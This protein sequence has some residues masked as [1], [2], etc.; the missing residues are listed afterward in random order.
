[1][2][3]KCP[4]KPVPLEEI[5]EIPDEI[6]GKIA[7]LGYRYLTPPQAEAIRKGLL[8][9]RNLIVSAPT[10]SGKTLIA[11]LALVKAYIDGGIGVYTCPLKALASEKYWEF[12][13]WENLL[14]LRVGISTGDYDSSG[15]DLEFYDLIVTTYERFDSILRHRPKWISRLKSLVIDEIHEIGDP[16]R[17]PVIEMIVARALKLGIQIIGLS[18]TIGNPW[19]LSSWISGDLV[20]CSWRPVPL[21]QG[22]YDKASGKIYYED[23]RAEDAKGDLLGYLAYKAY[24]EDQQLLIFRH[25]R[26][27][28]ETMARS[29]AD[30]LGLLR[31]YGKSY[32]DT[33]RLIEEL[34]ERASTR[35]EYESLSP[36]IMRGVAYHHAG[37]THGSR[38]VVEKGFRE[39][40]IKVVVATPTLAA[41]VN[42]PARRVLIYTRRYSDGGYD[43][44][45]IMEYKQMAGR[46]GR[47]QYDPYGEAI[48]A[49]RGRRDAEKYIF[50]SPEDIYSSLSSERSLRIHILSLIASGYARGERDL[51]E[52]FSLTYYGHKGGEI[53][54]DRVDHI[55]SDLI[56][57]GM[58]RTRSGEM[59]PTALGLVVSRQY[60]DPLTAKRA[61]DMLKPA[62]KIASDLWYLH[63]V[64]YTPDFQRSIARRSGYK[65]Y[66]EDALRA[67]EDGEIP[68]PHDED[69][70]EEEWLI[71]YRYAKILSAWIDE[72]S[73]D[74]IV[75]KYKIMPGD[76]RVIVETATWIS[77]ALSS[78]LSV[79]QETRSHS[80]IL[81]KLSI[82]IEN[83]IKEELIPLISIRGI[84]RMRARILYNAGIKSIEDL[85]KTD[86][87][88]LLNLKGFGEAIVKQIYEQIGN[89]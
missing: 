5:I 40:I 20:S 43:D 33:S 26:R 52:I 29:I 75:E 3:K 88:K 32:G 58:V 66:E 37:L 62:D 81:K 74:S 8:F 71:A 65:E 47:P 84:G 78:V 11:E 15:E 80:E 45:G 61:I 67:L 63:L 35:Y 79:L 25:S 6:R 28:A 42:L 54:K 39:R 36:L 9:G 22:F 56:R 85:R 70:S 48:I 12:K 69:I 55:L 60:I 27:E 31:L 16:E 83:G 64:T 68:P 57:W 49:D 87:R 1:M 44:I 38:Y 21:I 59:I 10:A 4:E 23:G 82:R 73:E 17:G 18:A 51:N 89:K 34:R 77:Y 53:A 24:T 46:A 86:P 14:G 7:S 76:L 72:E 13:R 30:K 50:G 2:I 19:D 41:G